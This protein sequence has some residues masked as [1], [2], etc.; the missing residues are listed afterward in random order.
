MSKI[1]IPLADDFEDAEFSVPLG[2]L[3]NANHRVV[4]VGRE[5]GSVGEGKRHTG[6]PGE[7]A[8]GTQ[9][10]GV[11]EGKRHQVTPEI[12]AATDSAD[13]ADFD[14]VLIPGGYSPD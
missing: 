6:T 8:V 9:R 13:P 14:M 7:G 10:G 5:A 1:V 2:A 4:V 3:C 11:V 12:E